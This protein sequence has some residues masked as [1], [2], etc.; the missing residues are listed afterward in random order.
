MNI[1]AF[2]KR[3]YRKRKHP[4]QFSIH[5]GDYTDIAEQFGS[6][7]DRVYQLAHGAHKRNGRERKILSALHEHGIISRS[8]GESTRRRIRNRL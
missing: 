4:Y 1:F 8:R 2:I 6:T 7:P 5:Q 3:W